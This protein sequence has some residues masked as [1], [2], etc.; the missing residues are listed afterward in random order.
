M[1]DVKPWA[2]KSTD[3]IFGILAIVD[4]VGTLANILKIKGSTRT[5]IAK[6]TAQAL[7]EYG[8]ISAK[9][10]Y[11]AASTM[12]EATSDLKSRAELCRSHFCFWA[13]RQRVERISQA[14]QSKRL[15]VD[16]LPCQ[17]LATWARYSKLLLLVS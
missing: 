14:C 5:P 15:T 4:G 17:L 1:A 3:D 2:V 16:G 10:V 12:Y 13:Q 7:D 11:G 6:G 9:S 8:D